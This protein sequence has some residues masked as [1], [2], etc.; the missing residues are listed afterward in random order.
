MI[1]LIVVFV[2]LTTLLAYIYRAVTKFTLYEYK[3]AFK[4]IAF[5]AVALLIMFTLTQT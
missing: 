3:M 4:I 2:L 5:A 1:Q